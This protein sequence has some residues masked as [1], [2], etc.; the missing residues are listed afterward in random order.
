ML[1]VILHDITL[2]YILILILTIIY[3]NTYYLILIYICVWVYVCMCVCGCV[4]E[5]DGMRNDISKSVLFIAGQL[6]RYMLV[7]CTVGQMYSW[8][9]VQMVRCTV[10]RCT[11][12]IHNGSISTCPRYI[13]NTRRGDYGTI[14]TSEGVVVS[15]LHDTDGVHLTVATSIVG[16]RS[17]HRGSGRS[18]GFTCG[19]MG[20]A[21]G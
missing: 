9:D 2:F 11:A 3:I 14:P 1:Y 6:V 8:S 20:G 17:G 7:R 19:A 18:D 15:V 12:S 5:R 4:C 16:F 21:E 13:N 10:I